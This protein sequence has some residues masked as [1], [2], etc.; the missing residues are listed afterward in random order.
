MKFDKLANLILNEAKQKT[1]KYSNLVVGNASPVFT[2]DDILR[3][4]TDP[5]KGTLLYLSGPE[6]KKKGLAK[7][8][9]QSIRRQIRRVNYIAKKLVKK[10]SNREA[11]VSIQKLSDDI[12]QMLENYQVNIMK[13]PKPDKANTGY[14][15]R[16]IGNLLLPPTKRTP[17]G[18]SVFM[19]PGGDP[20]ATVEDAANKPKTA[21]KPRGP[22][23][24][25]GG[26]MSANEIQVVFQTAV[27]RLD[28][29]RDTDLTDII[30]T[31]AAEGGS[32]RDVLSDPQIDDH[33]DPKIVREVIR[34]M[35][36]SGLITKDGEGH[37]ELAP[38]EQ[39]LARKIRRGSED[40]E[41]EELPNIP[42]SEPEAEVP[43]PG[44]YADE[45]NIDVDIPD[46]AP[47]WYSTPDEED[48]EDID[49]GDE[50]EV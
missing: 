14:E 44:D 6:E 24:T 1:E 37:L 17:Q 4:P 22:R 16:V 47:D 11:G 49:P 27:D 34:G 41:L 20:N 19:A 25:A 18:K 46:S 33:F 43:Q 3:D 48:E 32:V 28:V 21:R 26:G 9:P 39:S 8:D 42:V 5:S 38:E 23:K 15:T 12:A 45:E 36:K 31:H 7:G 2:P 30:K 40:P 29:I 50:D 13:W 10:Y 35:I